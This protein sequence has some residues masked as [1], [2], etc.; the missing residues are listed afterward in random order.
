MAFP[1]VFLGCRLGR[2][3]GPVAD[4][5][6]FSLFIKNDNNDNNGKTVS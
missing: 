2:L 4:T 5:G 3:L 1:S 6:E